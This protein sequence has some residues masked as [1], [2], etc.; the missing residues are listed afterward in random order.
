MARIN[1][2]LENPD[3]KVDGAVDIHKS[4]WMPFQSFELF[5]I[6]RTRC[7]PTTSLGGWAMTIR[8]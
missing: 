3:L 1:E 2:F 5:P 4:G 7:A 8:G 6:G